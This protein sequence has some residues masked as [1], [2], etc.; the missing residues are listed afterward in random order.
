MG[1]DARGLSGGRFGGLTAS[2]DLLWP[3]NIQLRAVSEGCILKMPGI[4]A[5][6]AHH[7]DVRGLAVMGE[8]AGVLGGVHAN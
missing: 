2:W 7:M 8:Y 4:L 1:V 5:V 3:R 6:I